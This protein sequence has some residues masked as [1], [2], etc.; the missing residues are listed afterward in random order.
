MSAGGRADH[1]FDGTWSSISWDNI[2]EL[3]NS[4]TDGIMTEK[5]G[6]SRIFVGFVENYRFA[7]INTRCFFVDYLDDVSE[8]SIDKKSNFVLIRDFDHPGNRR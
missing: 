2:E 8:Q 6:M 4:G 1:Y 3:S 5:D 7:V